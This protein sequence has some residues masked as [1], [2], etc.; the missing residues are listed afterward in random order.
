M[1][2]LGC[3]GRITCITPTITKSVSGC[4]TYV[5]GCI[6]EGAPSG[7]VDNLVEGFPQRPFRIRGRVGTAETN[8]D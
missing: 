3:R 1:E 5:L 8:S 7:I 4:D 6:H 2:R